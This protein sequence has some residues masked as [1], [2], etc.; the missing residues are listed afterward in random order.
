MQQGWN[1]NTTKWLIVKK[2]LLSRIPFLINN[3]SKLFFKETKLDKE[4]LILIPEAWSVPA[5]NKITAE[6]SA[7][8]I[9]KTGWLFLYRYFFFGFYSVKIQL[10]T[11]KR[12]YSFQSYYE[13]KHL[14]FSLGT[15]LDLLISF[16]RKQILLHCG[17]ENI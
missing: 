15:T 13:M 3:H 8:W 16:L 10:G 7:T 11:E 12:L 2:V 4:I 5:V 9:A 6:Q 14:T 17:F 1:S